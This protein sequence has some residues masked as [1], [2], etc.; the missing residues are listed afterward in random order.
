VH[1]VFT[2]AVNL[3]WHDGRL[4]TLHG[5]SSLRAPFAVALDAWPIGAVAPGDV[6][7]ADRD[8]LR[9]A[10]VRVELAGAAR[11]DLELRP[12]RHSPAQLLFALDPVAVPPVAPGLGSPL[13]R[14]G[15]DRLAEGIRRRDGRILL[16]GVSGLIGLGE[17]LTPAGDDCLVGAMAALHA[18]TAGWLAEERRVVRGLAAAASGTTI[19]ARDFL[20]SAADGRFAEA[21][22]RLCAGPPRDAAR[23]A[24]ELLAAGATSGADTLCGVRLALEALV[25][26][27]PVGP[28][29][30]GRR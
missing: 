8:A 25:Q 13:G 3:L 16:E 30:S 5:P 9:L 20:L 29:G 26:A 11:L 12:V 28:A 22:H 10:G 23:A 19:V 15:Q 1:S 6:V 18:F 17:G 7:E 24:T 4:L 21:L 2:Q 14:A 27:G